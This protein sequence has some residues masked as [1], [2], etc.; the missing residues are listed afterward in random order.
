MVAVGREI[1]RV[2]N[3]G[4]L[5]VRS[6]VVGQAP[7]TVVG[8]VEGPD[9]LRAA[10]AIALPAAELAVDRR[11]HKALAVRRKH[12]TAGFRN[13]QRGFHA[14]GHW[15]EIR[16]S[17]AV[18]GCHPV[19]TH[20]HVGTVHSP[21]EHAIVGAAAHPLT[22]D[23]VVAGELAGLSASGG[24][25]I[26]LAGAV[27]F[28]GEGDGTAI[29]RELRIQLLPRMRGQVHGRAAT[30]GH[31]VDVAALDEGDGVRADV[32][33]AQHARFRRSLGKCHARGHEARQRKQ[34]D[35]THRKLRIPLRMR[36]F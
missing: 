32:G 33:K 15:H 22:T 14:T 21:V 35:W 10:N 16:A 1:D 6:R 12:A 18:I 25:D 24:H 20:Q 36:G 3:P 30:G 17:A 19:G 28:G 34:K 26:N 11:V 8:E 4:R 13:R 7:C 9:I 27:V 31:G 29:G 23:V 2:A 5:A